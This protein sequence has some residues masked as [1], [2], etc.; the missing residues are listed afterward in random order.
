MTDKD[1][2]NKQKE[3]QKYEGINVE[4]IDQ[5]IAEHGHSR[6]AILGPRAL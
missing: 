6:E 1:T 2:N 4:L 5:W 3:T